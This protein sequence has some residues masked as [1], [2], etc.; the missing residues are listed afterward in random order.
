MIDYCHPRG[1]EVE[2]GSGKVEGGIG[3]SYLKQLKNVKISQLVLVIDVR[4]HGVT[5]ARGERVCEWG[6]GVGG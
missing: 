6:L 1:E 5:E 4:C 2:E 3:K